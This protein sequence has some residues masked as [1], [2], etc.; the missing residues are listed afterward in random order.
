MARNVQVPRRRNRPTDRTQACPRHPRL[1]RDAHRA[2]WSATTG[3][4]IARRAVGRQMGSQPCPP[5][6]TR[7]T[8]PLG[9][10]PC[11]PHSTRV[12][13]PR[14]GWRTT[15]SAWK[16]L[17]W[18]RSRVRLAT[19]SVTSCTHWGPRR[20]PPRRRSEGAAGDVRP[21]PASPGSSVGAAWGSSTGPCMRRRVRRSRSRPCVRRDGGCLHPPPPGASAYAR[22]P[23][24]PRACP[25]VRTSVSGSGGL[26]WYAMELLPGRTLDD[27][28]KECWART[29]GRSAETI[30]LGDSARTDPAS[31]Q[32]SHGSNTG[33]CWS[34]RRCRV[35]TPRRDRPPRSVV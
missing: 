17:P 3:A 20:T 33:R 34:S 18:W 10:Q 6:S 21:V 27:H 25:A 22:L 8:R 11:P 23:S 14:P 35:P 12:T 26:P 9:S 1:A 4:G 5:H 19:R 28:L 15:H 29:S 13:R 32:A 31:A 7:V 30:D 2:Y 16:G 24:P